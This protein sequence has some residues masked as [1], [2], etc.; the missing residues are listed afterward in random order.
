MSATPP[1]IFISYRRNDSGGHAQL[2]YEKLAQCFGSELVFF[3]RN[4]HTSLPPGSDWEKEIFS[5]LDHAAAVLVLIG[6]DWVGDPRLQQTDDVV[7]REVAHALASGALVIPVLVGAT[8]IPGVADLPADLRALPKSSA[9]ALPSSA[10]M[11]SGLIPMLRALAARDRVLDARFRTS[12]W[13]RTYMA[14]RAMVV[15]L[16]L[17]LFAPALLLQATRPANVAHALIWHTAG[18]FLLCL[19][20]LAVAVG[21]FLLPDRQADQR[22]EPGRAGKLAALVLLL[23]FEVALGIHTAPLPKPF[24]MLLR[25]RD[26]TNIPALPPDAK[27][28]LDTH[29][30]VRS[31]PVDANGEAQF[32]NFAP[33]QRGAAARLILLAKGYELVNPNHSVTLNEEGE[34]LPVRLTLEPFPV[35]VKFEGAAVAGARLSLYGSNLGVAVMELQSNHDGW[36]EFRVPSNATDLRLTVVADGYAEYLRDNVVLSKLGTDVLLKKA[37]SQRH[38]LSRFPAT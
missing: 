27:L 6:P 25:L 33:E 2:L 7:R 21:L 13:A 11:D 12:A 16:V 37:A 35:T 22:R 26:G 18:V 23:A 36:A 19:A 32:A 38:P 8:P 28:T 4:N 5:A 29:G 14:K 3:D 9:M 30:R 15:G 1:K 31:A 17:F 10:D 34:T 24:S 20:T